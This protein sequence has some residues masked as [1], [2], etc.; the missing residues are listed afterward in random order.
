MS[1]RRSLLFVSPILP[2][3][4]GNGLAMRAAL[5]LEA[6]AKDHDVTLLIIP[7]SGTLRDASDFAAKHARHV[8]TLDL[9]GKIDPLWSLCEHVGDPEARRQ[10]FLDY[11]R[12]ALCRYATTPCIEAMQAALPRIDFDAIHV[13]RAY[14]APYVAP[15][16]LA[17][18]SSGTQTSLDLDDDETLTHTRFAAL[19]EG[20][21]RADEARIEAAEAAKYTRIEATWL[22]YFERILVCTAEHARRIE[23]SHP[24]ARCAVVS[25]HVALPRLLPRWPHRGRHILFVGNLSY[26]PNVLGLLDFVRHS[27]SRIRA[28]LGRPVALRIAGGSPAKEVVGL[29][30]QDGVE[31]VANPPDLARHYHWADLAIVPVNAGGGTRIKLIEAF[32]HGVPVV[33]TPIG[34]EGI[35]VVAGLHLRLADSHAAFAEACIE[36]LA[37]AR[38]ARLQA[39]QAR[40]FVETGYSRPVGLT[41]I[42]AVLA[43]RQPSG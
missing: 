18:K 19:L 13:M 20:M 15:L 28:E 12:P 31:V 35:P 41:R 11:P 30:G 29:A 8:V 7:V 4:T 37:D 36:L 16:L 38:Q 22:T 9:D 23:D 24:R 27:L 3:I 14:L 1:T 32:A 17:A 40:N 10:A 26:L 33:S 5:F 39:R 43:P 21:G 2:A 42:R 34:A 25:N 6:L